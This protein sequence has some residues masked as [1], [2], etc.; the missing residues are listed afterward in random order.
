M[1]YAIIR[2]LVWINTVA[3]ACFFVFAAF[4]QQFSSAVAISRAVSTHVGVGTLL[5]VVGIGI[6]LELSII[7]AQS[8]FWW[9]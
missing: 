9:H 2:W 5:P 6:Y 8:V 7:T 1:G 3:K 4:Q